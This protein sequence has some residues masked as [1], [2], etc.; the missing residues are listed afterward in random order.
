MKSHF[1]GSFHWSSPRGCSVAY[2]TTYVNQFKITCFSNSET[3]AFHT[4]PYVLFAGQSKGIGASAS[5][6][7]PSPSDQF[8]I[9][10]VT[11]KMV[12][13]LRL[14]RRSDAIL[15]GERVFVCHESDPH[16][17]PPVRN[18]ERPMRRWMTYK[19]YVQVIGGKSKV[20]RLNFPPHKNLGSNFHGPEMGFNMCF[21]FQIFVA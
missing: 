12:V 20:S 1:P 11:F 10:F 3:Q 16:K 13:A 2:T 21:N 19:G 17:I 9:P 6:H 14:S 5:R 8:R 18:P 7:L 4:P 15:T